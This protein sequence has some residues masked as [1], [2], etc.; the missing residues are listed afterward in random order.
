MKELRL[1]KISFSR[2][3]ISRML[4]EVTALVA[5]NGVVTLLHPLPDDAEIFDVHYDRDRRQL[6]F[7]IESDQ[8]EL[9]PEGAEPR[10]PYFTVT[11]LSDYA[12]EW[13]I[14]EN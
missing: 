7:Y 9:L 12:E 8:Y 2:R 3:L 4:R 1:I 14:D 11:R 13:K 6:E 10:H 5:K